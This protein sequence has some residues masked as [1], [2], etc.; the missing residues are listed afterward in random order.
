MSDVEGWI[1]FEGPAPASVKPLLDALRESASPTPEDAEGA[2]SAVLTRV[3]AT[4]AGAA[5][6]AAELTADEEASDEGAAPAGPAEVEPR[7]SAPSASAMAFD[8]WVDLSV[9]LLG[10]TDDAKLPA[11]AA[12]G[13]SR[14]AWEAIDDAYLRLLSD[15]LRAGREERPRLYK[16]RCDQEIAARGGVAPPAPALAAPTAL[17]AYAPAPAAL[18]G[19]AEAV[20]LPA[21]VRAQMGK[22]PFKPAAEAEAPAGAGKKGIAKTMQTPV[23]PGLKGTLPL[24]SDAIQRAVAAVPFAG[25][26]P[27]ASVPF[28]RLKVR[29]YVSLRVDLANGPQQRAEIL[30]RYG[31]PSEAS[32]QAL[33]AHWREQVAARPELRAELHAA[34]E[35]YTSWLLGLPGP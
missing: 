14:S 29:Q 6:P 5:S 31:V 26:A 32:F 3:D 22:L 4:L 24:G 30:R 33:E 18:R 16:A 27:S 35:A 15:D 11:L 21:I 25:S 9:R 2:L 1:W 13:L 34:V 17:P 28:P 7:V 23:M 10:A 20:D 8:A 19:T 12:L